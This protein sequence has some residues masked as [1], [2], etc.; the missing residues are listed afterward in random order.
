M[1]H[2][3]KTKNTGTPTNNYHTRE[4]M[5][6]TEHDAVDSDLLQATN[7]ACLVGIPHR[8]TRPGVRTRLPSYIID[9]IKLKRRSFR[10]Y[11]Q[12]STEGNRLY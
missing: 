2:T 3:F 4:L 12:Q 7:T 1:K 11:K 5:D 8:M 6:V 10:L 9:M